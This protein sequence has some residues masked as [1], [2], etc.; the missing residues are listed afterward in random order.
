MKKDD[1][2]VIDELVLEALKS[3]PKSRMDLMDAIDALSTVEEADAAAARLIRAGVATSREVD[4]VLMFALLDAPGR[5]EAGP[6]SEPPDTSAIDPA[7]TAGEE[8]RP[9][10]DRRLP[11]R[12]TPERRAELN[13]VDAEL[14]R[15]EAELEDRISAAKERLKAIHTRRM[16]AAR[17]SKNETEHA[18]IPC[19]EILRFAAGIGVVVRCD[20]PDQWPEGWPSDGAVGDPRALS[21][22]DMQTMLP[23]EPVCAARKSFVGAMDA[24]GEASTITLAVSGAAPVVLA[25]PE[26]RAKR[27]AGP[28]KGAKAATK[29]AAKSTKKGGAK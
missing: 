5:G 18:D 1:S 12:I 29:S 22:A 26:L 25:S 9:I 17:A 14:S 23:I 2:T 7:W 8:S 28:P 15:E 13:A 3:G 16:D 6:K 20:S 11:R 10:A 24:L 21:A 4:G 27:K 19:R